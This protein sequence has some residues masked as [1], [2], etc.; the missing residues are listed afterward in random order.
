MKTKLI[1]TTILLFCLLCSISTWAESYNVQQSPLII[2]EQPNINSKQL[3][4]LPK[5]SQFQAIDKKNGWLEME[6]GNR[7]GFV[8]KAKT[9][10]V[11][12]ERT[13]SPKTS[14]AVKED[15]PDS[16]KEFGEI[17]RPYIQQ[18]QNILLK[19]RIPGVEIP[20]LET[21]L[22]LLL[23]SIICGFI[24]SQ[25]K[26]FLIPTYVLALLTYFCELLY[27]AH[28]ADPLWF[29]YPME[30]EDFFKALLWLV[31]TCAVLY[32]QTIGTIELIKEAAH[33]AGCTQTGTFGFIGTGIWIIGLLICGFF[34]TGFV[35]TMFH[36]FFIFLAINVA[37]YVINS[38]ARSPLHLLFTILLFLLGTITTAIYIVKVAIVVIAIVMVIA[39][40]LFVLSCLLGGIGS[41]SN[42]GSGS[43]NDT[44]T[45]QDE[46]GNTLT[47]T[48]EYGMLGEV[49]YRDNNGDTWEPTGD[50]RFRRIN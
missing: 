31:V 41:G 7:K 2:Y 47:A 16:D 24:S 44:I 49:T 5:G 27:L 26:S 22:I 17:I 50:G 9:A 12:Q 35:K 39:L 13:S 11:T 32:I 6:I 40:A 21:S 14:T 3:K 10:P 20:F 36:I 28:D 38:Q 25:Y 4:T 29:I 15:K 33:N 23:A 18:I 1:N 48:K 45:I 46:Y 34:F 8:L 42:S 19:F 37:F 43:R 30:I